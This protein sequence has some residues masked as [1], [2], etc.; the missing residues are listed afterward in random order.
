MNTQAVKERSIKQVGDSYTTLEGPG[1]PIRRPLPT[2]TVGPEDVD[3]MLMLDH[4]ELEA[5]PELY[6]GQGT[7]YHRGFE[8]ITYVLTGS[9]D[10]QPGDG[11]VQHIEQGGLQR[12]TTG[13]GISHGGAPSEGGGGPVEALQ[14]WI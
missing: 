9:V 3:P 6:E 12:I 4:A 2:R 13:S 1:I 11:P 14:I 5:M 10:D 7:H 8:V